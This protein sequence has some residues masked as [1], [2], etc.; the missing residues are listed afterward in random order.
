ML[1][2]SSAHTTELPRGQPTSS[3][4]TPFKPILESDEATSVRHINEKHSSL[5]RG[6]NSLK[7]ALKASKVSFEQPAH[8]SESDEDSFEE[9]RD[10]F[11]QTKAKSADHRGILKVCTL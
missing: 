5:R 2:D 7:T 3:R 6:D 9:R 4:Q 8:E 10:H 1:I 11:Q